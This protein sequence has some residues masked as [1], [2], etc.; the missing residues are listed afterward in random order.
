ML[1]DERQRRIGNAN[2]D[3]IHQTLRNLAIFPFTRRL[4]M[5]VEEVLELVSRASEDAANPD[6][7]SYFPL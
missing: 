2:R 1:I 7:K 6:L 5:R 3:T 4:G